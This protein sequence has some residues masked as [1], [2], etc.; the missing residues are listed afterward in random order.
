MLG[1]S[2]K[3]EAGANNDVAGIR[4]MRFIIL[5]LLLLGTAAPALAADNPIGRLM[6]RSRAERESRQEQRSERPERPARSE[7]NSDRA[8]RPVARF[9][10]R[11][12]PA[13]VGTDVP[14]EAGEPRERRR[15]RVASPVIDVQ[16]ART[17]DSVRDWRSR[18][19]SVERIRRDR[20]ERAA[21]A[22]DL[23]TTMPVGA[24]QARMGDGRTFDRLRD[25]V[26]AEGWR[27]EWRR[28]RRYDWRRYRDRD[29]SRFRIGIYVDPFG[30]NYRPWQL[31]G[32]LP[33]RFYR[34]G[35]WIDDPWHYRL[36]PAYG[37]YRWVRYY[38]DVLLIDMRTGRIVDRIPH[39]FW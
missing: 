39:F 10:R 8:E 31:G 16:E 23:S 11:E 3:A 32:Y 20:K 28:D 12:R 35:Y 13:I 7:Q 4:A 17:P 38:D 30:W 24:G 29:R 27:Q 37:P 1:S 26:S 15:E 9:E 6:E 19:R 33:S 18:E 25:R 5:P 36:P 14:V 22:A 2:A 34:S 21:A